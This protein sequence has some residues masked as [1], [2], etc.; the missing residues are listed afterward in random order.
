MVLELVALAKAKWSH[1]DGLPKQ[2]LERGKAQFAL[3]SKCTEPAR[4]VVTI[5]KTVSNS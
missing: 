4:R 2:C 5:G 1:M 3:G